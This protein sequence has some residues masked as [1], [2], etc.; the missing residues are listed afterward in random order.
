MPSWREETR[1]K[2]VSGHGQAG[3]ELLSLLGE[4]SHRHLLLPVL[5]FRFQVTLGKSQ[6][7]FRPQF[8]QLQNKGV[9]PWLSAWAPETHRGLGH[10]G[11]ANQA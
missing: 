10:G 11:T 2:A 5:L 7:P 8:S 6:V 1:A 3:L 9:I 4:A